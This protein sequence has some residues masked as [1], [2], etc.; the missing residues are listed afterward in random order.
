MPTPS[1]L[2]PVHTPWSTGYA[3]SPDARLMASPNLRRPR[4]ESAPPA[5]TT[6][7]PGGAPTP[8]A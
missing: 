3:I 6:P 4:Q 5:P 8:T 7:K 1:P 2:Y